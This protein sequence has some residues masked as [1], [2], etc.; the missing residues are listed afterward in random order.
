[1]IFNNI[2]FEGLSSELLSAL[3]LCVSL[4][5]CF[6]IGYYFLDKFSNDSK[7]FDSLKKKAFSFWI[8]VFLY[9]VFVVFRV[10]FSILGFS[11]ISFFSFKELITNFNISSKYKSILIFSYFSVF[12][13]YFF[14]FI[15][16]T[17]AAY[18]YIPVCYVIISFLI[19][20]YKDETEGFLLSFGKIFIAKILCV[21]LLSFNVLIFNFLLEPAKLAALFGFLI[22]LTEF[23]DIAQ[24]YWGKYF[25][26]KKLSPTISPNKT[27]A[28]VIGGI[29]TTSL[30]AWVVRDLTSFNDVVV[31]LLG[32]SIGFF[33]AMGDLALSVIKRDLQIK[34]FAQTIPGHGG[35]MDRLDSLVFSAPV[36]YFIVSMLL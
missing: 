30:M 5:S 14:I 22:F 13:H 31:I 8:L 19:N 36:F 26:K 23:N 28:G 6:T 3:K 17:T 9:L 2:F 34:D 25:G 33:G 15:R 4:L 35:L 11:I 1:M 27:V 24:Y 29:I 7:K 18:L 20:F 32:I 21:Y 12:I 10:R 16:W